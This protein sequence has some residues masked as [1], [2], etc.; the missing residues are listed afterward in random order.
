MRYH[1]NY[2]GPN[3]SAGKHQQSVISGLRGIDDF[4]EA[5]RI[6]DAK[7][8]S[9]QDLKLADQEFYEAVM[10]LPSIKAKIAGLLVGLQGKF[11]T[12]GMKTISMPAQKPIKSLEELQHETREWLEMELNRMGQAK[13]RRMI[14]TPPPNVVPLPNTPVVMIKAPPPSDKTLSQPYIPNFTMPRQKSKK[15]KVNKIPAAHATTTV[16]SKPKTTSRNGGVVLQH[17]GLVSSFVGSTTFTASNFQVNP[18][19][20]GVFPWA[21]QLARSYDKYR[22][23]SLKFLYRS[24]VPTTTAGVVMMSFDYDT[25]DIL[26]TTKFEHSQTTPNVESNSFNSFELKVK[27]DNVWR[28]VRQGA[29][30]STDLKTYD[31]GQLVIS[32]S[33]GAAS[34]LGEI[35]VEYTIELDKPSHGVAIAARLNVTAGSVLNPFGTPTL[36]GSASPVVF[37]TN[38]QMKFTRPGEY[39]IHVRTTGTGL[40]NVA[41]PTFVAP[42]SAGAAVAILQAQFVN[43]GTTEGHCSFKVRAGAGDVLNW[44]SYQNATTTPTSAWDITETEY[45]IY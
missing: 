33:Y 21:S 45:S 7:Y 29:V 36:V 15:D 27:C 12:A 42:T 38:A 4:D 25:L 13:G 40:A 11:R 19:L 28:F 22:F 5:C 26:P 17:K 35:Y 24:V 31:F 43:A 16:M 10:K 2:C 8:A 6:H 32:S 39:L 37:P 14:P 30:A 44:A 3:W 9:G 20:A 23:T 1:G 41:A 18:G 34:L